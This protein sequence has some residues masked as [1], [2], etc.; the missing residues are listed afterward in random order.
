MDETAKTKSGEREFG[1]SATIDY[2]DV[3]LNWMDHY[4]RGLD[5]GVESAKP[6]RYFVMGDNQ[7]READAWP[8]VANQTSYYLTGIAH[9][10]RIGGLATKAPA[11]PERHTTF[12]SDPA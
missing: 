9:G 8:P 6:V 10:M 7:W 4:L 3:V 12:L 1:Q 2:D 5:N 11:E